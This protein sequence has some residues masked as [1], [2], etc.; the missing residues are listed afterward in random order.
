SGAD[1]MARPFQA[2]IWRVWSVGRHGRRLAD[3]TAKSQRGITI[4]SAGF[5]I[6]RASKPPNG[7]Q[8]WKPA[9]QQTG[10]SALPG[11]KRSISEL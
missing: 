5:Q 2:G 6:G 11:V 4:R 8:V 3:R 10:K 9:L 7:V 1:L